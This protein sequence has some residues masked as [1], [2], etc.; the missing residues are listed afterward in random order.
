MLTLIIMRRRQ[1]RLLVQ[2]L[3][4]LNILVN[5]AIL[6]LQSR[7]QNW[8]ISLQSR[9]LPPPVRETVMK[10]TVVVFVVIVIEQAQY[11]K[12]HTLGLSASLILM[13]IML[14]K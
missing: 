13:V 1:L 3:V 7:L 8:H 4:T 11:A 14:L 10:Y 9:S 12:P 5:A 2:G 6:I